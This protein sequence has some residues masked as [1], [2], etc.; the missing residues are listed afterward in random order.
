MAN[1]GAKHSLEIQ[2][3][4]DRLADF[5]QCSQLAYRACQ[6]VGPRL[7]FLKQADVLNRDDRLVGEG[8]Y[9]FDLLLREGTD[10]RSTDPNNPITTLLSIMARQAQSERPIRCCTRDS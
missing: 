4:A 8:L 10:L 9:E 3:R 2:S 6:F 7:Q 1:D 5:A